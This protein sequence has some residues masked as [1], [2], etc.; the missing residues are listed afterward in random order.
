MAV[1]LSYDHPAAYR[2]VAGALDLAM[3]ELSQTNAVI[4]GPPPTPKNLPRRQQEVISSNYATYA[5]RKKQQLRQII[6]QGFDVLVLFGD[7]LIDWNDGLRAALDAGLIVIYCGL[8]NKPLVSHVDAEFFQP[9]KDPKSPYDYPYRESPQHSILNES[10][11]RGAL[12]DEDYEGNPIDS[13]EVPLPYILAPEEVGALR[14]PLPLGISA[15]VVRQTPV[16]LNIRPVSMEALTRRF[17]QFLRG[18]DAPRATGLQGELEERLNRAGQ[19]QAAA[20]LLFG[21]SDLPFTRSL[22]RQ[23]KESIRDSS[24]QAVRFIDPLR[25]DSMEEVRRLILALPSGGRVLALEPLLLFRSAQILQR[26]S[27]ATKIAGLGWEDLSSPLNIELLVPLQYGP[28]AYSAIH[29]AFALFSGQRVGRIGERFLL[30][31]YGQRSVGPDGSLVLS[32]FYGITRDPI[33]GSEK[34]YRRPARVP[35]NPN[36]RSILSEEDLRY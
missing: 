8:G 15:G 5:A 10:A 31:S 30:G 6:E 13:G 4:F 21:P 27:L 9:F 2:D 34:V 24:I 14:P 1:L 18:T 28:L 19:A 33:L 29:A 16:H 32:D 12:L 20:L 17:A 26:Y 11:T 25:L 23:M 3:A 36:R 35:R 22:Y 7:E